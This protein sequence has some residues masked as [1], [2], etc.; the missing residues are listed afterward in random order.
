MK[1]INRS[2]AAFITLCLIITFVNVKGQTSETA[3]ASPPASSIK[4]TAELVSSYVWRGSMATAS[5]TPNIQPTLSYVK[6][7]L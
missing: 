6:G 1:N 5:A 3:V 2:R 4:V 7:N